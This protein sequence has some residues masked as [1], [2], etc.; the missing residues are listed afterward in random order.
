MTID[1]VC[2]FIVRKKS[3][4]HLVPPVSKIIK[5]LFLVAFRL[6]GTPYVIVRDV[7]FSVRI[8][9]GRKIL[10]ISCVTVSIAA[11]PLITATYLLKLTNADVL[12]ST[13]RPPPHISTRNYLEDKIDT[14][15]NIN[16]EVI[17]IRTFI[18]LFQRNN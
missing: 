14:I 10:N 16:C 2:W 4:I 6:F 12:V 15:W 1:D 13:T 9:T 8:R 17:A 7:P 3:V 5:S 18:K 11:R